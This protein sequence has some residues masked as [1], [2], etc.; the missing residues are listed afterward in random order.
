MEILSATQYEQLIEKIKKNVQDYELAL[1]NNR[2]YLGLANGD[3]INISFPKGRIPHLLGVNT[4]SLRAA[5]LVRSSLPAYDILKKLTNYDLTYYD[6]KNRNKGYDVSY[7]F[8]DYVVE[9][10]EIFGDVLKLRS[11]DIYCIIK[12]LTERTYATGEEKEN[13][14]YFIVR[15]HNG[16][17]S[18]LGIV[19]DDGHNNYVPVTIRSFSTLDEL[20][21]FLSR[22][23]RNQE[24]TY[25]LLFRCD[26]YSQEY[27]RNHYANLDDKYQY[28]KNLKDISNRYNAIP[29]TI[30]DYLFLID[31]ALNSKQ[32]SN[33]NS[34]II[35]LIRDSI[36]SGYIIDKE[37]IKERLDG[38]SIS[39]ELDQLIDACNDLICSRFQSDES[40]GASYSSILNENDR[41]KAEN[42]ALRAL[43]LEA[44]ERITSLETQ[45]QTLSEDNNGMVRKL[46]ILTD[47]YK[48]IQ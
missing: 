35:A 23:S 42:E 14:D 7:L 4:D 28:S 43:L 36:S 8:S 26:N 46:T 12:Y 39:E 29:S 41:V 30:K 16:K 40:V 11:D 22:V 38:E 3:N 33:N 15:K 45:V 44:Q 10:N 37:E 18:V 5:N 32:K 21:I 20:R 17:Y 24:V 1:G 13:S 19:K 2:F 27:V 48:Q 9:K 25:P 47:A 34:S 6:M 31:K